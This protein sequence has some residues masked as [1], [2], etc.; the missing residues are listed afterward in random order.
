MPKIYK[1]DKK[2]LYSVNNTNTYTNINFDTN[3]N[4]NI[5]HIFVCEPCYKYINLNKLKNLLRV[6]KSA[7]EGKQNHIINLNCNSE[8]IDKSN[9]YINDKCAFAYKP[10]LTY[11]KCYICNRLVANI[12]GGPDII[13]FLN[14]ILIQTSSE[15]YVSDELLLRIAKYTKWQYNDIYDYFNADLVK[16]FK[17][18]RKQYQN[19]NQAMNDLEGLPALNIINEKSND[20]YN[21]LTKGMNGHSTI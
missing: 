13:K 8:C 18:S 16:K 2:T 20:L 10:P 15:N 7:S 9:N 1:V 6:S 4:V 14:T 5:D 12:I 17:L 21:Y 3:P 11:T 19:I